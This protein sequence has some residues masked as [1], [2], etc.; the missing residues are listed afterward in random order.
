[1][2]KEAFTRIMCELGNGG[3]AQSLITL[4]F[5]IR[6]FERAGDALLN[7]GEAIIFSIIGERIKI[8]QFDALQQTLD[9]SGFRG[10]FDD[11]DF[12]AIWG[13]RSGCRI[14]TVAE[15]NAS[16]NFGAS[17]HGGLYKEGSIDKIRRERDN[18]LRWQQTLPGLVP[19]IFGYHEN[20]ESGS[21]LMEFLRGCTLDEMIL[22]A[23]QNLLRNALFVLENT[24]QE[25]WTITHT[26]VPAQMNY[27]QQIQDRLPAIMQ[28][29]P[30]FWRTP[31]S[32]GSAEVRSCDEL[33][34]QS[35]EAEQELHSPFTVFIHGDFNCNNIVYNHEFEKIHYIDV[36]RS[37]DADYVQ[38]ISVFLVSNFRMPVFEPDHR[39][40]I[41]SVIRRFYNFAH[42][43]AIKHGDNLFQARLT[44]ALARSFYTS[45]RFEMNSQFARAMFN[46]AVFLLEKLCVY[47][48]KPWE[49]F[50]LPVDV[51]TY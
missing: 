19:D 38:D 35:A 14:G 50:V 39:K 26:P 49:D 45:T 27:I 46:R 47:H 32:V 25:T 29:H 37:T 36:Y 34:R 16:E 28:V 7:I 21:L 24:L 31:Q 1:M 4:L 44:F 12:K 48:G 20:G 22:L 9:K 6:Y 18:L 41:N 33:L 2:Y 15:K 23:D 13:S 17:K 5:I 10:T 43:F 40:R 11:I 51:L 42:A 3:P 8:R 30:E